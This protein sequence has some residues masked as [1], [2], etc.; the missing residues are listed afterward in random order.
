LGI[1]VIPAPLSQQ[2]MFLLLMSDLFGDARAEPRLLFA[3]QIHGGVF[4]NPWALNSVMK[5]AY[6]RGISLMPSGSR[7]SASL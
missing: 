3:K 5:Q 4:T 2:L 1:D 6:L 7:D